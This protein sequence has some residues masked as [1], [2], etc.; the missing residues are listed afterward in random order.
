M[1]DVEPARAP[2]DSAR[3]S[4]FGFPRSSPCCRW[5]SGKSA[6]R[7]APFASAAGRPPVGDLGR[8]LFGCVPERALRLCSGGVH[9][10]FCGIIDD[11][12]AMLVYCH[13]LDDCHRGRTP[14]SISTHRGNQRERTP[15]GQSIALGF[16][17]PRTANHG[18]DSPT[19]RG[20][21]RRRAGAGSRIR[22]AIRRSAR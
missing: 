1:L 7:I 13:L 8:S 11:P 16:R 10:N 15:N 12:Q 22:R 4:R 2:L 17:T 3:S 19:R 14:F 20:V 9:K 18:H 6:V 21:G 5:A